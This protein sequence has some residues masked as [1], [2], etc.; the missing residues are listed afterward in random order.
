MKPSSVTELRGAA[1]V[2]QLDEELGEGQAARTYKAQVTQV[3]QAD[4]GLRLGQSVVLKLPRIQENLALA[5]KMRLYT[6]LA[7]LTGYEYSS[8]QQL[9]DLDCVAKVLDWG[10]RLIDLRSNVQMPAIF[11]VQE[12]IQGTTLTT[13]LA[14]VYGQHAVFSGVPNAK[15]FFLWAWQLA[16]GLLQIHRRQVIHGDIWP[17]NIMVREPS[18][19]VFI[20]FGQA[21][22]RD[23]VFDH[24]KTEGRNSAYIAPEQSRS[25]G[26]DIYSLGGV[27]YFLATG[28]HPLSPT[29]D[30]DLLKSAVVSAIKKENPDLYRE[31]CGIADIIARCLR[32]SRHGRIPHAQGL[33]E[34]IETFRHMGTTDPPP[35]PPAAEL[36]DA[37]RRVKD[38]GN[39]FFTWIAGLRAKALITDLEDMSHDVCDLRGDHETL[40]SAVTQYVSILGHGD[41][42][43][44]ISTPAYWLPQNLG[45]QGRFLSM[46]KL[47]AQSG[48]T[49]RRIFMVTKAELENDNHLRSVLAFHLEE[50]DELRKAG[51]QTD[52]SR[53]AAGGYYT[54]VRVVESEERR[55]AM[56][57][58]GLHFGLIIKGRYKIIMYPVYREDQTLVTMQFRVGEGVIGPLEQKFEEILTTAEPL[59]TYRESL[60]MNAGRAEPD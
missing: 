3:L 50:M 12:H 22:F 9:K 56:I 24:S 2:Y 46:N 47:A 19:A 21:I 53:I 15:D 31:N 57:R 43:L 39:P 6:D 52:Q 4:R 55:Q 35:V 8:L 16:E 38:R 27:L 1:A 11:L 34:D 58:E 59:E 51:V 18:Q 48:A 23:L 42:Y 29:E 40:V 37:L 49:I 10:A 28:Q 45:L 17:A 13:Y 7:T 5:D 54:C 20:D 41:K 32:H 14:S 44:T 25:V 36:S 60:A 26:G 30:I 33:L